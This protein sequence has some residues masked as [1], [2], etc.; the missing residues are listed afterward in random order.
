M[1][2]ISRE[3]GHDRGLLVLGMRE[4]IRKELW[5]IHILRTVS[6]CMIG[7]RHIYNVANLTN[8]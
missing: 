8:L 2:M 7:L 5:V 3:G 6:A 1:K 4:L